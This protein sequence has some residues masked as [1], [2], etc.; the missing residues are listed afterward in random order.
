MNDLGLSTF[1]GACSLCLVEVG[2]TEEMTV[3]IMFIV[4]FLMSKFIKGKEREKEMKEL[5][6]I[7]SKVIKKNIT[8]L[9]E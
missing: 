4:S 6:T 9:K 3:V 2:L 1:V 7:L 8:E 5:K